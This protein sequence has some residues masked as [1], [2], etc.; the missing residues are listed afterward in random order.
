M[1]KVCYFKTIINQEIENKN[2]DSNFQIN[3]LCANQKSFVFMKSFFKKPIGLFTSGVSHIKSKVN[4]YS[5]FHGY[6]GI[7]KVFVFTQPQGH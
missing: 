5:Y 7:A 4:F 2:Y 3:K 1:Q 6:L